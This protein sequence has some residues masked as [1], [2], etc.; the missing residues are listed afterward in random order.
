MQGGFFYSFGISLLKPAK[1]L[2]LPRRFLRALGFP[3]VLLAAALI[4]FEEWL[5]DPLGLWMRRI[6]QW[7]LLQ[8]LET[9]IRQAPPWLA[10]MLFGIPLLTLLPFKV[11][12]LWLIAHRHSLLGVCVFLSAKLVG[13]ALGARLLELTQPSLMRLATFRWL[14]N[15][16]THLREYAYARVHR[17]VLWR[18]IR[19]SLFR[20]RRRRGIWM[21]NLHLRWNALLRL[22]R[23]R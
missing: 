10:L 3:L 2:S 19:L 7:P 6:G 15:E 16:F 20:W 18:R 8:R 13:T 9:L 23:R 1:H 17:N 22:L 21:Q 5:W 11:A 12:G 4:W 14:W